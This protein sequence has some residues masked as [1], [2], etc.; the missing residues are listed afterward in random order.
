[1]YSVE[2]EY[3]AW[4]EIREHFMVDD[5]R[6]FEDQK[7]GFT[8]PK[9]YEEAKNDQKSEK[10]DEKEDKEKEK[11]RKEVGHPRKNFVTKK[12]TAESVGGFERELWIIWHK[13]LA[14]RGAYIENME[15]LES[16]F[17]GDATKLKNWR[18]L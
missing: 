11:F 8:V 4:R 18:F 15:M 2:I 1:M 12:V 9:V 3:G 7:I 6:R 5:F 10:S 14:K 17:R 13:D 16:V